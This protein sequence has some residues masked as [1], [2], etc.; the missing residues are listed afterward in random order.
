MA[1]KRKD[2]V[3]IGGGPGGYVAAIRLG[4]LGKSVALIEKESLGGV[5]LN[6]GCIP[7]KALIHVAKLYEEFQTAH[8]VGIQTKGVSIDLKKTQAWKASIVKKLTQGVRQLSKAVG[9]E[10]IKGTARFET[11]H[12][13]SIQGSNSGNEYIEF[14]N[15]IIACG[16]RTIEIPGFKIDGKNVVDSK[17]A[18]DWTKA[19]KRM[20]VIGGGVIGLEMGM[21]YQKFGTEVTVVELTDQ[22][23]PGIDREAAQAISRICKKKKITTF[24][25]SKALG[26]TQK[27][28]SLIVEVQTPKG[29]NKIQCNVILLAVGRAPDGT[30]LGLDKIG[31]HQEKG[32]IP[33]NTRLQTNI[34]NIF[35]IGDVTGLPLLAHKASKEG[36]VAAEII[37]GFPVQYDVRAMPSAVF[38]DPEIAT[39]GLT[40]EEAKQ[41]GMDAFSGKFPFQTSGRALSTRHTDGFVKIVGE[42]GS[43]LLLGAQIIGASASDLISEIALGIE[44]GA[45]VEDIALTVHPHPTTSEAIMEAAEASLGKAIHTTNRKSPEGMKS[46]ELR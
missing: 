42:R 34:P 21:L 25:S 11:P 18:L 36:I 17:D 24:V 22:L 46:R 29:K 4:Q 12:Q 5:C 2:T 33:V 6:W 13:V 27:K 19:P 41:K 1:V 9:V 45:T 16:S 15:A 26:Y 3:V 39:V 32:R 38:T 20:V 40:E 10:V 37:A 7:S 31:V 30:K 23:L 28:G 14:E 43:N 44:M 8:E 35:A